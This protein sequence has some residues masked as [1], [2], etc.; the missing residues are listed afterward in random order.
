MVRRAGGCAKHWVLPAQIR[1]FSTIILEWVLT[2]YPCSQ[3]LERTLTTQEWAVVTKHAHRVKAVIRLGNSRSIAQ[4]VWEQLLPD[5]TAGPIQDKPFPLL[6]NLA[7]LDFHCGARDGPDFSA[8]PFLAGH[9]LR[10]LSLAA[11]SWEPPRS[12][13][14][15]A[16]LTSFLLQT[17]VLY[18][19]LE[20]IELDGFT[21][22]G[23][24]PATL[25][26]TQIFEQWTHIRC[27]WIP[28]SLSAQALI[29]Q[30][31]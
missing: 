16:A 28:C 24:E 7:I 27:L 10:N 9:N 11:W 14:A 23:W 30:A 2:V 20:E 13:A 22:K 31:A 17:S 1:E 6:P 25:I 29:H 19:Y 26:P 5:P 21:H 8:F 18:P 3:H 15:P 4:D 12:A